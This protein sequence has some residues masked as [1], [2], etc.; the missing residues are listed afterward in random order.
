[1]PPA[2]PVRFSTDVERPEPDEEQTVQAINK[3]FDEILERTSSDYG[4]AVRA[5]HA[6]AHAVLMGTLSVLPDLPSDLAQGM[7]SRPGDHKIYMRLSTNAGDILPDAVSL[8]RGMALKVLDVE[9]QRLPDAQGNTQDFVLVNGKVFQSKTADEFLANLKLLA[10]TTDKGEGA[11]E[12]FSTVMRGVN[13]VLETVGIS[14]S[15]VQNL[16]GAPNSDPLG[17]S[18]FSV[19]PFRYGDYIAK[20]AVIPVSPDL[21][22]QT[23]T[24]IDAKDRP[25]ALR[26]VINSEMRTMDAVWEFRVQLCRDLD[27][28]P[29]EDPTA[30]WMEADTPFQTVATIHVGAQDSWDEALVQ[31]VENGTRFSIW[32]GLEAHRP[33]GNINRARKAS[34]EHSAAFRADFNSC[35][36]R[37]PVAQ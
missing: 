36:I 19:T 33:L 14:S 16:G 34:Y 30:E 8:P 37:E 23:G 15:K 24:T 26:E 1:M 6:K 7:F 20:F 27:A 10:K 21:T 29:I 28:Q 31:T 18:Y 22:A 3:A 9:G 11:K 13:T 35:P 17:E 12:A 25:D 5:V 4:Y 2:Q 32:T